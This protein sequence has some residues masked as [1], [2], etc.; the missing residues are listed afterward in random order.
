MNLKAKMDTQQVEQDNHDGNSN[1][2]SR[3]LDDPATST[4]ASLHTDLLDLIAKRVLASDL[5]DYVRFRAVCLRWRVETHSPHGRGVVDPCFHPRQWMMFPEGGGL[6]PGHPALLGYVR[7]FNISTGTFVRVRLPYMENY[8]VLDCLDGLLLL[9]SC[10]TTGV[11]PSVFS[12]PSL[13]TSAC[14][15]P[16]PLSSLSWPSWDALSVA[17]N[18][19]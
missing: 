17:L 12:T 4:W 8:C 15:R 11:P 7:F 16:F 5:L 1:C 10:S 9:Q 3:C 18:A 13:V 2:L 6:F 14:S 19:H